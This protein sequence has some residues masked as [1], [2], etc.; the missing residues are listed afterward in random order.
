MSSSLIFVL[1][2]V[3]FGTLYVVAS[4]NISTHTSGNVRQKIEV[5]PTMCLSKKMLYQ[6]FVVAVFFVKFLFFC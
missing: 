1:E 2:R 4:L 6:Y 5:C 3:Y